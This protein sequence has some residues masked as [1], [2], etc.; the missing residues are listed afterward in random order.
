MKGENFVLVQMSLLDCFRSDDFH[1]WQEKT[2]LI[3]STESVV[4]LC[5]FWGHVILLF[6]L[7]ENEVYG[8]RAGFC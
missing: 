7:A 4:I 2:K 5:K 6:K 3:L 1:F 8:L